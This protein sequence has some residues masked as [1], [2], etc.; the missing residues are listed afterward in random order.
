MPNREVNFC[1]CSENARLKCDYCACMTEIETMIAAAIQYYQ[2]SGMVDKRV[3]E[4]DTNDSFDYYKIG[5][6]G[7]FDILFELEDKG[8]KGVID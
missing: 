3:M 7:R 2:G 5:A 6:K 8:F 1:Y 4:E